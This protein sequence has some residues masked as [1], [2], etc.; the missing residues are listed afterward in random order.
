[1][2]KNILYYKLLSSPLVFCSYK[3][4]LLQT[5][6]GLVILTTLLQP[7]LDPESQGLQVNLTSNLCVWLPSLVSAFFKIISSD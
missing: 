4:S 2:F 7:G 5:L 3:F 1:M 6:T